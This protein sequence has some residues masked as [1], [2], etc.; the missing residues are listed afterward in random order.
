MI[1]IFMLPS[2]FSATPGK[3]GMQ[4]WDTPWEVSGFSFCL[5]IL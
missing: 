1:G 2:A 5:S 3:K 4:P